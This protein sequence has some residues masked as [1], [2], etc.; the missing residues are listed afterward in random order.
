MNLSNFKES[1]V[2]EKQIYLLHHENF[3]F[4]FL[5]IEFKQ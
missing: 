2:L 4:F 5:T 3:L 1:G